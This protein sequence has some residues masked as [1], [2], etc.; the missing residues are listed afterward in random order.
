MAQKS[1]YRFLLPDNILPPPKGNITLKLVGDKQK[2]GKRGFKIIDYP[3][4]PFNTNKM[5]CFYC[6]CKLSESNRTKD[7]VYPKV[8]GGIFCNG[9]K[10]YAC[11]IC[12]TL[13]SGLTVIQFR[14]KLIE[15][16]NNG[17]KHK[18]II[19]KLTEHGPIS[20]IIER[21]EFMISKLY[22]AGK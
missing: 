1:R 22:P 19:L 9:N 18:G 20:R 15:I 4:Y 16:Q 12:N 21:V 13:K 6:T 8:L 14:E 17:K 5:E 7:H 11:N 2:K 3:T 10:V